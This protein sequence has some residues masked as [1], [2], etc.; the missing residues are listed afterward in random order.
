MSVEAAIEFLAILAYP[1]SEK[2]RRMCCA[3]L[4]AY[5]ARHRK[6]AGER[7]SLIGTAENQQMRGQLFRLKQRLRKRLTAAH[8]CVMLDLPLCRPGGELVSLNEVAVGRAVRYKSDWWCPSVMHLAIVLRNVYLTWRADLPFCPET[9]LIQ[10]RDWIPNAAKLSVAIALDLASSSNPAL[11]GF[12]TV[13]FH[14]PDA[15]LP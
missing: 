4:D 9:L 6:R 1:E 10:W 11:K 14:F 12:R 8:D 2:H 5:Y 3:A 15:F 7:I 13:K